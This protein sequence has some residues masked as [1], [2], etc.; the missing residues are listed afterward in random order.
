MH[1]PSRRMAVRSKDNTPSSNRKQAPNDHTIP[2]KRANKSDSLGDYDSIPESF[3]EDQLPGWIMTSIRAACKKMKLG[4]LTP[5]LWA[6]FVSVLKELCVKKIIFDS[7]GQS[8]KVET[9]GEEYEFPA[10]ALLPLLSALLTKTILEYRI[11]RGFDQDDDSGD[12]GT[13]SE[14]DVLEEMYNAENPEASTALLATSPFPNLKLDMLHTSCSKVLEYCSS[15]GL[16][17]LDCFENVRDF[18]KSGVSGSLEVDENDS[19][20]GELDLALPKNN[21]SRSSRGGGEM[22]NYA[23]DW[24][25]SERQREYAIWKE[26]VMRVIDQSILV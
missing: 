23:V 25:S 9:R 22:L 13:Y 7:D 10:E 8:R 19:I 4:E 16:W 15:S 12:E 11:A 2:K 17:H 18:A 3:H 5:H 6:V 24:S 20:N 21:Q 26:K 14:G 1:T